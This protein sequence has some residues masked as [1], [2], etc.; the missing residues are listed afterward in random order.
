[1]CERCLAES[2]LTLVEEGHYILPV[3]Q[4]RTHDSSNLMSLC[5]LCYTKIH[6][7]IGDWL[8]VFLET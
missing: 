8:T 2:R 6:H 4:G 3:S 5:Q 1:M 7:E